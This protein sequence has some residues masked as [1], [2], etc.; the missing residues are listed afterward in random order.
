MHIILVDKN[1]SEREKY[2]TMVRARVRRSD[3][4][5]TFSSAETALQYLKS[6]RCD[7]LISDT[8]FPELDGCELFDIAT[9]AQ[10]VSKKQCLLVSRDICATGDC[11]FV[12]KESL[13]DIVGDIVDGVVGVARV[14]ELP[15]AVGLK[16]K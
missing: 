15:S 16:K 12:E 7:F 10:G 3:R 5:S 11:S 2:A 14:E 6:H 4:M 1:M 9:T 8:T 13:G